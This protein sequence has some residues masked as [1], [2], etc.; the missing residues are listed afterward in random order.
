[1]SGDNGSREHY[2]DVPAYVA[3]LY[4]IIAERFNR[5]GEWLESEGEFGGLATEL[6]VC[7]AKVHRGVPGANGQAQGNSFYLPTSAV[8][9]VHDITTR[10]T[11]MDCVKRFPPVEALVYVTHNLVTSVDSS[12]RPENWAAQRQILIGVGCDAVDLDKLPLFKGLE[13][14]A[15][16]QA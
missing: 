7:L 3:V 11:G 2:V 5:I 15:E 6:G 1:M 4:T 9:R 16:T 10:M 13:A 12:F 8:Q 14:L